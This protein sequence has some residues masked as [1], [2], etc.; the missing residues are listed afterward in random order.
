MV[1]REL[2]NRKG[3]PVHTLDS[4]REVDEAVNLMAASRI[5]AVIITDH[6]RPVGIFAE[7][8]VLRIYLQSGKARFGDLKLAAAMTP[9][10]ISAGPEEPLG[11]AMRMMLEAE[12]RH[13]PVIE[14]DRVIG[15]LTISDLIEHRLE[16]LDAELHHLKE[17]ISDLHEAE[18]D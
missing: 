11:S 4:R 2:L 15:M 5:G 1:L 6:E 3:R 13:L 10:L 18:R 16:T 9:R 14:N 8:D 7:R 17:Y 12:I